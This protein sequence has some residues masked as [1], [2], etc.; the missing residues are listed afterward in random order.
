MGNFLCNECHLEEKDKDDINIETPEPTLI[1]LDTDRR[2]FKNIEPLNLTIMER[3]FYYIICPNLE[4]RE[5]ISKFVKRTLKRNYCGISP[6]NSKIT[7]LICDTNRGSI[8]QFIETQMER[9]G[10]W[11]LDMDMYDPAIPPAILLDVCKSSKQ[12][13]CLICRNTINDYISMD[14]I[15]ESS[16][17]LNLS[18]ILARERAVEWTFPIEITPLINYVVLADA[19]EYDLKIVYDHF[20]KD[21]KIEYSEFKEKATECF[22]KNQT[23]IIKVL[24]IKNAY[25]YY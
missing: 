25:Y 8:P 20:I 1:K 10:N 15:M 14:K 5:V 2:L 13:A 21:S 4:K 23:F 18:Y 11:M 24:P 3:G 9:M 17:L 7:F 22:E 16:K 6:E 19:S 12:C